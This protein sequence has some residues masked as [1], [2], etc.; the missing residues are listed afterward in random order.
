MKNTKNQFF[1]LIHSEQ[2]EIQQ[3]LQKAKIKFANSY[4]NDEDWSI[5]ANHEKTCQVYT[6][7]IKLLQKLERSL[8]DIQE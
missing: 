5:R 7:Q 1:D 6:G 4:L 2:E 3:K 8:A